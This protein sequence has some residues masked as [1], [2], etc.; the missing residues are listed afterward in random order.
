M[1]G[2]PAYPITYDYMKINKY[3]ISLL[4]VASALFVIAPNANSTRVTA[5]LDSTVMLMGKL[6]NLK[7]KVEL[8]EGD[9]GK[10]PM[11]ERMQQNGIIGLCGDSV[12]LRAPS[13][14]DTTKQNGKIVILYNLP[15]QSFDSGYYK[16][17]EIPFVVG[18]DTAYSN[19]VALK[20]VPVLAE[21]TD[22]IN[23]YA[24]VADPEGTTIF[25]FL[26]DWVIDYWWIWVIFL[27]LLGIGISLLLIYKKNGYI[28]PRKPEPTPYEKAIAAL[29]IL[30][31]EKLWQQGEEKEFY[32]RL[33]D[34]LRTYL[35]GRFG[36]NAM[37][38]TSRQILTRLKRIDETKSHISFFKQILSM[39]DFVKFAKVRPL[40]EDNV[41]LMNGAIDFVEATKPVE[42]VTDNGGS[43]DSDKNSAKSDSE[44]K[45]SV[46]PADA[47]NK[48]K[49]GG[50]K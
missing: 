44:P 39:A 11:L 8:G 46:S 43:S 25:D 50:E 7:L 20:V 3:I 35:D 16:L 2:S 49:K 48:N 38:M 26:P 31:E 22:P 34:I 15:L 21:A 29:N 14:I 18:R 6:N 28:L 1:R 23:D 19:S 40:P 33:T 13:S 4:I 10:L 12:E 32:T 47:S 37:E 17:P 5:S 30:K 24:N 9:K 45:K 36:L 27:I 42:T 41:R